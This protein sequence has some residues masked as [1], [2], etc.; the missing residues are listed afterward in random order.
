MYVQIQL[1]SILRQ[2]Q[3]RSNKTLLSASTLSSWWSQ[4]TISCSNVQESPKNTVTLNTLPVKSNPSSVT[5]DQL[6]V[7]SKSK[8]KSKIPVARNLL[9]M[10]YDQL[11]MKSDQLPVKSV[12]LPFKSVQLPVKSNPPTVTSD[13]LPVTAL[14]APVRSK[15][16]PIVYGRFGFPQTT[17]SRTSRVV[18]SRQSRRMISPDLMDNQFGLVSELYLKFVWWELLLTSVSPVVTSCCL[19]CLVLSSRFTSF[20]RTRSSLSWRRPAAEASRAQFRCRTTGSRGH[21]LI[22][23]SSTNVLTPT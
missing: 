22:D 10:K 8:F 23:A 3:M 1:E 6:P 18:H 13:P 16:F 5:S 15:A 17:V 9:P 7:K 14:L 19:P 2:R 4:R 12:Q 20:R 21:P 11:P